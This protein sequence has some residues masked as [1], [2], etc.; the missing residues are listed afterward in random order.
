M[1]SAQEQGKINSVIGIMQVLAQLIGGILCNAIY[2]ATVTITP[3]FTFYVLSGISFVTIILA[4][5]LKIY[6]A[7]TVKYELQVDQ[8][9]QNVVVN[10]PEGELQPANA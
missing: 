6:E 8:E 4:L 5:L 2:S 1:V 10:E 3:S 7:R 9:D